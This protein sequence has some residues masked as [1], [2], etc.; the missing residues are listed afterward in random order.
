MMV[1]YTQNHGLASAP[2]YVEETLWAVRL[3]SATGAVGQ[4]QVVG[5]AIAID[6]RTGFDAAGNVHVVHNGVV[7]GEKG[8]WT[9]HANR[10]DAATGKW[11]PAPAALGHARDWRG[12]KAVDFDVASDG[13]AAA[14]WGDERTIWATRWHCR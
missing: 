5:P 13:S 1:V 11:A 4:P 12:K 9:V 6:P 10:F 8:S 2:T 7:G 3:D 14:V